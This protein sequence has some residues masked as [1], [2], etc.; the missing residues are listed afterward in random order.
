MAIAPGKRRRVVKTW[1][2]LVLAASI[3]GGSL[4]GCG[5]IAGVMASSP[6]QR[7]HY[8]NVMIGE[9]LTRIDKDTG[10]VQVYTTN[11]GWEIIDR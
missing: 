4:G 11:R 9:R 8:S 2:L 10:T 1:Q 6:R 3:L 5:I 7:Y